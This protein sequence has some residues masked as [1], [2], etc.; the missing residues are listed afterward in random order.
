MQYNIDS[1]LIDIRWM[2][3]GSLDIWPPYASYLAL[4][5]AT[6]KGTGRQVVRAVYNDQPVN[7]LHSESAWLPI[8]QFTARLR[9]LSISK[10]DY[11][12]ACVEITPSS[13]RVES[14]DSNE[15]RS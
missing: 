15:M 12:R 11:D 4:E 13:A 2:L 3:V 10:D 14:L 7:M 8:E 9:S 6:C 5:V 1:K